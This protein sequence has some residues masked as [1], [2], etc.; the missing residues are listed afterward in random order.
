[1]SSV[2]ITFI[3]H[4]SFR[5]ESAKGSVTYFDAW[6]D[7][8]PTAHMQLN[9][10]EKADIVIA[11]H[12]HSD[13]I[14]DSYEICKRTDAKFVGNY[15]LCLLAQQ[16]HG[17]EMGTRALSMNPGGTVEVA[18]AEITMV[19]AH[20]SQSL[21]PHVTGGELPAGLLFHPDSAVNGFVIAYDNGIT[22]YDT[23]DTCLFSD[24]QLIGQM[25]GPQ[26]AIMPVG[27]QYTMGVREAARAASLIRPDIVIP[28]HYGS[29]M[30]QPADIGCLREAVRFL[31]PNT[32][33][34]EMQPGQTLT[35]TA[36]SYRVGD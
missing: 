24:M 25:Y 9:E 20:H 30:N 4:A 27:G 12:G 23:A 10:V 19:Q 13:H 33:V 16:V 2:K 7:D 21:S 36:S 15:E 18:D 5:F 3:G 35:Y 1:M 17:L 8:N 11:S 31:S 28:C 26:V 32:Q 6:L 14:G 34:V 22:L 29:I